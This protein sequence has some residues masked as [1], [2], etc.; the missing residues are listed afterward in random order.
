MAIRLGEYVER[1][2]ITNFS[3]QPQETPLAQAL[4]Q[5][6]HSAQAQQSSAQQPP[7]PPVSPLSRVHPDWNDIAWI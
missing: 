4:A 5:L 2:G 3:G 1:N 7:S 6:L